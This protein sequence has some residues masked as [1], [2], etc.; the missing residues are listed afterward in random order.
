M[1]EQLIDLTKLEFWIACLAA[2]LVLTPVTRALP[3]KWVWA[4]DTCRFFS[5]Y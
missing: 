1:T 2:V 4:G 5:F 3:R